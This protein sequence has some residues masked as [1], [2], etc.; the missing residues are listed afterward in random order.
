MTTEQAR[1]A[2]LEAMVEK[3]R[4]AFVEIEGLLLGGADWQIDHIGQVCA[5]YREK[6]QTNGSK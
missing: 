4:L 1:I 6:E 2:E 3:M 5:A